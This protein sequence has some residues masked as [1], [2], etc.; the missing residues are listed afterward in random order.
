[1]K[2][3]YKRSNSKPF[4]ISLEIDLLDKKKLKLMDIL[5]GTLLEHGIVT[6]N[7]FLTFIKREEKKLNDKFFKEFLEKHVVGYKV[8]SGKVEI[9]A[10]E[11]LS[12]EVIQSIFMGLL[13]YLRAVL[14]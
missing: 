10:V 9:S 3:K 13:N 6:L 5:H 1:M 12:G 7:P 4:F 11:S 8:K 14:L 2:L